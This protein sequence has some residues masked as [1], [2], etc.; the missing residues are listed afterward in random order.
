MK[1][2]VTGCNGKLG[3]AVCETLFA[4]GHVVA[5]IDAA[6]APDRPHRVVIDTLLN[7]Y[8]LHR[9]FEL[10]GGGAD[11]VV[12]L[13][14]HVNSLV[15]PAETV[16]RENNAINSSVFVGSWQAGVPRIVFASSVQAMIGGAEPDGSPSQRKPVRLPIDESMPARPTNVYGLSKILAEQM[17]DHLCAADRF[18]KPMSAVSVRLPFIMMGKWFE[19]SVAKSGQSDWMWG[20]SECYSYIVREDAAEAFR[21]AIEASVTGH[22]IVWCAAP[23]PRVPLGETAATLLDRYYSD[24]PGVEVAR[25]RD[26]LMNCDKA[27]ALLGWRAARILREE[28]ERRGLISPPPRP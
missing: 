15:G 18:A 21:L 24:V 23:D 8:A 3:Q 28:R 4:A 6:A 5:G 7:P 17:L 20:G 1:V 14:N 27:A 2:L 11:A 16:F 25:R 22:E 12:H 9:G 10:L 13:A 26:S 19:V